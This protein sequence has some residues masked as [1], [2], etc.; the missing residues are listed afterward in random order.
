[1]GTFLLAPPGACSS[2][3]GSLR[4]TYFVRSTPLY[5]A[6]APSIASTTNNVDDSQSSGASSTSYESSKVKI[7]SLR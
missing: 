2:L 3:S 5:G 7:A 1:M 4:G 6:H